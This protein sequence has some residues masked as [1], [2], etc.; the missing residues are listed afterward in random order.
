LIAVREAIR[1][2]LLATPQ[3]ANLTQVIRPGVLQQLDKPPAILVKVVGNVPQ[4]WL[5]DASRNFKARVAIQAYGEDVS[6]AD[7]IAER[8]RIYALHSLLKGNIQ[9]C[10]IREVSLEIGPFEH[11]DQPKDGSD[12]WMRSVRQDFLVIYNT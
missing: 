5:N 12:D 3:V 7:V 8:I 1:L 2:H 10:D 9:G 11:E 6:K 4:E